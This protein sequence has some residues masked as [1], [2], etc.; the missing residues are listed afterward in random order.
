MTDGPWICHCGAT[1]HYPS[2]EGVSSPEL[3]AECGRYPTPEASRRRLKQRDAASPLSFRIPDG[4]EYDE[5][6]EIVPPD[7]AVQIDWDNAEFR[8]TEPD[9]NENETMTAETPERTTTIGQLQDQIESLE[10]EVSELSATTVRTMTFDQ[11]VHDVQEL[12]ERLDEETTNEYGEDMDVLTDDIRVNSER[13]EA[14]ERVFENTVDKNGDDRERPEFEGQVAFKGD[15][16]KDEMNDDERDVIA[17]RLDELD[18]DDEHLTTEEVAESLDL[19]VDPAWTAGEI[20]A[21]EKRIEVLEDVINDMGTPP[22]TDESGS[23]VVKSARE[24]HEEGVERLLE[25][26]DETEG[27][28]CFLCEESDENGI[29]DDTETVTTDEMREKLDLDETDPENKMWYVYEGYDTFT[30]DACAPVDSVT[31]HECD[32]PGYKLEARTTWDTDN[33]IRF[34]DRLRFNDLEIVEAGEIPDEIIRFYRDA[35]GYPPEETD[36]TDVQASY[37][38][39][40]TFDHVRDRIRLTVIDDG[41]QVF[42]RA[43]ELSET[44]TEAVAGEVTETFAFT[45]PDDS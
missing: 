32:D 4:T 43:W 44:D 39:S 1:V 19:E 18:N 22:E 15:F 35:E 11:L 5:I 12:E 31:I 25:G 8:I 28:E 34:A 24:I 16:P 27:C 9:D 6:A 3:C 7:D 45:I 17:D 23:E 14:I 20:D 30:H 29:Q 21:L 38:C 41:E 2:L 36:E 40:L 13:I 42:E 10:D 26:D 33:D 37:D